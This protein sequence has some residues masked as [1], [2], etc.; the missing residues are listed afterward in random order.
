MLFSLPESKRLSFG[1]TR[2]ETIRQPQYID[3]RQH[4]D[5]RGPIVLDSETITASITQH[6]DGSQPP[7]SGF[8]SHGAFLQRK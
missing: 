8:A 6:A 3:T 2:L 5:G 1:F 7:Q 4:A